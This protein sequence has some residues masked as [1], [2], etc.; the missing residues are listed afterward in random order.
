MRGFDYCKSLQANYEYVL[1]EIL[2]ESW[3]DYGQII[4]IR[5]RGRVVKKIKRIVYG[6]PYMAAIETTNM[7]N[8]NGICRERIGRLV[9]KSK[10]FSKKKMQLDK[11]LSLFQFYW[12]FMNQFKRKTSPAIME[13]LTDHIWSWD[14]FLTFNSAV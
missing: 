5:K 6:N 2:P 4:K 7:E 13:E 8:F 12:D 11:S 14:E 3:I 1:K 10:C 9:R